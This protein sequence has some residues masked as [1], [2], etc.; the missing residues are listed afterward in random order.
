[1]MG[2]DR[3]WHFISLWIVVI[4]AALL[5]ASIGL[6]LFIQYDPQAAAFINNV[7]VVPIEFLKGNL[8]DVVVGL[9]CFGDP[10]PLTI[11]CAIFVVIL[12]FIRKQR[13]AAIF[14]VA[15][16]SSAAIAYLLKF[17]FGIDRPR[18]EA[19]VT[20]PGSSSYPSAHATCSLVAYSLMGLIASKSAKSRDCHAALSYAIVGLPSLFGIA[21]GLSRVYVGVHWP[22]DV[23]GGFLLALSEVIPAAFM[24]FGSKG[25]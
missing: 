9:T 23:V 22:T 17:A 10:L 16:L 12:L 15:V 21:I 11:I 2:L 4:S 1:M 8:D 6:G 3:R 18:G 24:V 20:I 5:M 13:E 7:L 14:A 19:M 25:N